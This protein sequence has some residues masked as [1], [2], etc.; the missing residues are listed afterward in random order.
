MLLLIIVF[1][2]LLNLFIVKPTSCD[3][4][5]RLYDSFAEI[6]QVYNGPLRF[7]QTDWDNIK[8]ESII[9][10]SLSE[11]NNTNMFFERRIIRIN[12][13]MTGLKLFAASIFYSDLSPLY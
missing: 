13:N 7:R 9:L 11:I 5:V 8:H 12:A 2:T 10:R 3:G 6:Q 1:S 4:T